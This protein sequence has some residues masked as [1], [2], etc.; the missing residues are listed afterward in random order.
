[1][2]SADLYPTKAR[3]ALLRDIAN[4]QVLTDI[5]ADDDV[6]LLF[7]DAPTSWQDRRRVTVR[8]RELEQ[9]GWAE[10]DPAGVTW[11]LTDAG[12]LVCAEN[13]VRRA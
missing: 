1:M 13:G 7:P 9:A 4:G 10:T 12:L 2:S 11:Q 3:L 5:T 6:V 8:V